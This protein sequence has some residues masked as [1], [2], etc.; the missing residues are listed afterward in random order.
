MGTAISKWLIVRLA[1]LVLI[2]LGACAGSKD[3]APIPD[4]I[5]GIVVDATTGVPVSGAV[6]GVDINEKRFYLIGPEGTPRPM[7][8]RSLGVRTDASGEFSIDLRTVKRELFSAHPNERWIMHRIDVYKKG[9][10]HHFETY[11][12]AGQTFKLERE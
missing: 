6:V 12:A 9:Y 1:H 2:G 4:L 5:S 11:V 10:R 7:F 8:K 3:A